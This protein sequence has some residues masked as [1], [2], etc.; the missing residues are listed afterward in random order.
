[1]VRLLRALRFV[2]FVGQSRFQK[3]RGPRLDEFLQIVSEAA[4]A[5]VPADPRAIPEPSRVGRLQFRM[6]CAQ[7]AR[8]D[9]AGER[10]SL[11]RIRWRLF[12]TAVRFA[13]G[14]GLI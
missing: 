3:I 7:Y 2:D 5:E 4:A 10:N 9:T 8:R 1:T 6:L 11:W 13:R 14:K 12:C